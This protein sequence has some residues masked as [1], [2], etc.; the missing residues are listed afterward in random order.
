MR[1]YFAVLFF[2]RSS[3]FLLLF[4]TATFESILM[5]LCADTCFLDIFFKP[6]TTQISKK[7][8]RG[9]LSRFPSRFFFSGQWKYFFCGIVSSKPVDATSSFFKHFTSGAKKFYQESRGLKQLEQ[10][11]K[12]GVVQSPGPGNCHCTPVPVRPPYDWGRHNLRRAGRTGHNS[13]SPRHSHHR[14]IL[15]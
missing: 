7:K 3:W 10:Q 12:P 5:L 1:P 2:I 13:F 15:S 4:H 9:I 8:S 14:V 11:R 6:D